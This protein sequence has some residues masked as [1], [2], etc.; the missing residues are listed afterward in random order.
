MNSSTN[1]FTITRV[2]RAPRSLVFDSW[3][4][5]AHF[6]Q[7]FPPA[8]C[9]AS[10]LQAD[11]RPGGFSLQEDRWP[12]GG[13]FFSKYE[14]RQ[15]EP[16]DSLVLVMAFCTEAGEVV[17]HPHAPLWPERLRTTVAFEEEGEDTR[18]TVT[19]EPD[20]ATDEAATFFREHL[21]WCD[22]GWNGTFDRLVRFLESLPPAV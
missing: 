4:Q 8:D 7:W 18:L 3:V 21:H 17:K 15:V 5:P 2:F 1:T 20:G 11:V 14:Y 9:T 16:V 12:D 22:A 13:H 10:L 6:V 19:W